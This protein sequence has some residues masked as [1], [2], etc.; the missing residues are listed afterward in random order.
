[1]LRDFRNRTSLA[2]AEGLRAMAGDKGACLGVFSNP[3]YNCLLNETL[4]SRG[5][6]NIAPVDADRF[7][8][9]PVP[10][11][12]VLEGSKCRRRRPVASEVAGGAV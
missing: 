12:G 11:E 4:T 9:F 8:S 6:S 3:F 7:T 1:M 2:S 10:I 5:K